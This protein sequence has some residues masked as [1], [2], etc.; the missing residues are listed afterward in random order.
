MQRR[1]RNRSA[2]I[3]LIIV[4]VIATVAVIA[5]LP[6]TAVPAPGELLGE[7]STAKREASCS[8]VEDTPAYGGV[9][10][11]D[12]PAYQDRAHVGG[13]AFPVAPPLASY[14][15]IPPA[16]GPHNELPLPAG[17]YDRPPAVDRTIHSLEHGGTVIW[18]DPEASGSQLDKLLAF[19]GRRLSDEQ[20]GQDRVI[21]APYDY[22]DQGAA[23]S[24]QPGVQMAMVSWGKRETCGAVSLAAAFDFTS[25]YSAPPFGSQPY[26]GE[27][28]QAGAPF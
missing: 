9:E 6:G 8:E 28:P 2:G 14:S 18:Y 15:T 21:V 3:A 11:P 12:D 4:G 13:N 22:P 16:S 10:D 17:V 24:L 20:V 1:R 25:R 27:A 7:A 23:G 26:E 19:Y 5:L